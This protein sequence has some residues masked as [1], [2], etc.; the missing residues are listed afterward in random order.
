M[1]AG[2]PDL[3]LVVDDSDE[4][5][6]LLQQQLADRGYEVVTAA[7][8][9]QALALVGTRQPDAILLDH[10]LPGL[11]GLDVLARLR[12]DDA[13]A[14]VPVIMLTSEHEQALLLTS[15]RAGAHDHLR[16]P[17]DPAELEAR[18]AAALRVKKLN[19][20][21]VDAN[22]RLAEQA[23]TD[24][25]TGLANRRHGAHELERAVA[26]AVRHDHTLALARIDIDHF[27]DVND[28]YGNQGGDEVLAEVARRLTRAI[29]GGDEFVVIQPATDRAGAAR[30]A[31]R[32]RAAI[33]DAPIGDTAI[34]IS[35]GWAHWAG[36]TP[37]DL[38][39]R[40]DRAL[41]KAK[42]AGRNTIHPPAPA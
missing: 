14:A 8:G 4:M 34:T 17:F 18:V 1:G 2:L 28:T 26:L 32:L 12:T 11:S 6:A 27:K 35:V 31:E 40:A 33:A 22:R 5:R 30:A 7:D 24:H 39:A 3:L 42:D 38:L 23:L 37:D 21:L 13:L 20:A 10:E 15:L 25:L 41:Y 36:D 19:D 29:R 16:K 9:E